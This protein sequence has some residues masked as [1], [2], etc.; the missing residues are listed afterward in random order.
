MKN[1]EL[2]KT[3]FCIKTVECPVK[4][5]KRFSKTEFEFVSELEDTAYVLVYYSGDSSIALSAP[6]GNSRTSKQPFIRNA[7]IVKPKV[8]NEAKSA[9]KAHLVH[10]ELTRMLFLSY[11]FVNILDF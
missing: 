2:W 8:V 7:P 6:H 11:S 4:G 5:D 9:R 3:Y 1:S 10:A